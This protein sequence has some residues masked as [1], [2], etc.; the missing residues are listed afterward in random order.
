LPSPMAPVR[1]ASTMARITSS[2]RA[3][4]ATILRVSY[5]AP[6]PGGI[7]LPAGGGGVT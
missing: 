7:P 1:T 3:D 2:L 4:G 5:C 6:L